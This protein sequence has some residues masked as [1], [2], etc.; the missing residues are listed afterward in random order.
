MRC[1]LSFIDPILFP[2]ECEVLEVAPDR[3]VY[4]IFI[5]GSSSLRESGFRI[6]SLDEVAKLSHVEVYV[7]EPFDRY[8][9]GV[10]KYL[11][12]L[13]SKIDH[14]TVLSMVDE[15][16]FLNRH[17]SL[18]FHWLVNL[19]RH[20]NPSI[21]IRP[22]RDLGYLTSQTRHVMPRDPKLIQHFKNH[23]RLWFYLHLDKILTED[24]LGQTVT[25]K[26]ILNSIKNKYPEQ[27]KEVIQ[28]SQS[29]CGVLD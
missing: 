3:Y 21:T 6:L 16:L 7:R 23:D 24:L 25:F 4:N 12:D 26:D 11:S 19:R 10:Q 15:F 9:G 5:N 20:C 2:D 28:R 13:D 27:Y 18:Q 1:M 8:V 17:F 29:I 22:L 14:Q